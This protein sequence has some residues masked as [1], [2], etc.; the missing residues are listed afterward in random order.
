MEK[1]KRVEE[2]LTEQ[3]YVLMPRH[4]NGY[5]RLFG[6]LLM[7]WIDEIAGIVS[8]R[9]A[10]TEVTTAEIDNL[11][12]KSGAHLNNT[13]VLIGRITWVGSTSMEIRVDTYVED[14]N[15][16]RKMINRAYVVMVAIDKNEMVVRVPRL[17]V[18]TEAQKAEWVDAEKRYELRK[19][20]RIEAL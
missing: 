6:G 4:I 14:L 13:I 1:E 2:S 20:R 18:E 16:S 7:Q 8:K 15:G 11:Q 10:Q 17:L 12:F 3:A 5:G 19:Q 9:H